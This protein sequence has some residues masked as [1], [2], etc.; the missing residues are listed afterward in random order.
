MANELADNTD[1]TAIVVIMPSEMKAGTT[2]PEAL[3]VQDTAA[4]S[5]MEESV[6]VPGQA[7]QDVKTALDP[8]DSDTENLDETDQNDHEPLLTQGNEESSSEQAPPFVFRGGESSAHP[9]KKRQTLCSRGAATFPNQL[10]SLGAPE[11][12]DCSP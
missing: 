9:R 10:R 1:I 2:T 11:T 3:S 12:V 8:S 5:D 6:A 4:S 7:S